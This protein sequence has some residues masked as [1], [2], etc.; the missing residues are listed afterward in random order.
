MECL[1]TC[2]RKSMAISGSDWLEVPTR[3]KAYI[4]PMQG[5]IP[6]KYGLIWYSTSILGSWNS[7]W[8]KAF[9]CNNNLC[10]WAN[11]DLHFLKIPWLLGNWNPRYLISSQVGLNPAIPWSSQCSEV[12]KNHGFTWCHCAPIH[13][14]SDQFIQ[15]PW[16]WGLKW[17][18]PF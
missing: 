2:G 10:S 16:F 9:S 15:S 11:W 1:D 6:T 4:R 5:N 17:D 12:L 13:P 18:P 7:H 14:R 3:Y 8:K